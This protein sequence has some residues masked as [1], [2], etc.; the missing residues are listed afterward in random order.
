MLK[1]WHHMCIPRGLS[2]R[3]LGA[4]R[5]ELK[6]IQHCEKCGKARPALSFRTGCDTKIVMVSEAPRAS[7]FDSY[8]PCEDFE[9]VVLEPGLKTVENY[10]NVSGMPEEPWNIFEFIFG[11]F[12]P[13]FKRLA[14]ENLWAQ[15]FLDQV[16]WTHISKRPFAKGSSKEAQAQ[17]CAREHIDK[18]IDAVGPRLIIVASSIACRILLGMH[19]K[20]D[21]FAVGKVGCLIPLRDI[22][23]TQPDALLHKCMNLDAW[24]DDCNVA[25]FPNPSPAAKRWKRGMFGE[26]RLKQIHEYIST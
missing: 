18:E 21:V 14:C 2:V 10:N 3:D 16:Y 19:F 4:L 13:L 15:A 9:G 12:L 1:S 22:L 7:R 20:K 24:G 11:V 26:D 6:E 8:C 5:R 25:I 17:I 23:E